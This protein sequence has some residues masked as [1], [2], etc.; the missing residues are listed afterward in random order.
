MKRAAAISLYPG[1]AAAIHAATLVGIPLGTAKGF[2]YPG[3]GGHL[4][5]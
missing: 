3:M 5:G 2:P 1:P 4:K